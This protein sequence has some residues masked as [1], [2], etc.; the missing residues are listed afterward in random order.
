[1]IQEVLC[2]LDSLH[3]SISSKSRGNSLRSEGEE[4]SSHGRDG[5]SKGR[6]E[7]Q[8]EDW[9]KIDLPM[10][11]GEEVYGWVNKIERFF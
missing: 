2:K 10:F 9:R 5:E 6:K 7:S 8:I 4:D 3:E 11:K 1:M